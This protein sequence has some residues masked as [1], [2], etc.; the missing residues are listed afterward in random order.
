MKKTTLLLSLGAALMLA[1]CG[2]ANPNTK[3][4][5]SVTTPDVT[6]SSLTSVTTADPGTKTETEPV[7]SSEDTETDPVESS[8]LSPEESSELSPEE[9]SSEELPEELAGYEAIDAFY[10]NLLGNTYDLGVLTG[11]GENS[12]LRYG[13]SALGTNGYFTRALNNAGA[14]NVAGVIQ[15]KDLG[16]YFA[17][18]LNEVGEVVIGD[19]KG[20]AIDHK[21]PAYAFVYGAN[22]IAEAYAGK[23]VYEEFIYEQDEEDEYHF[24]LDLTDDAIKAYGVNIAGI[25]IG[26]GTGFNKTVFTA[27]YAALTKVSLDVDPYAKSGVFTFEVEWTNE[28]FIEYYKLTETTATW[29]VYVGNFEGDYEED[30]YAKAFL[31]YIEGDVRPAKPTKFADKG[32]AGAELDGVL[33]WYDGFDQGLVLDINNHA[34]YDYSL[35]SDAVH[36]YGVLLD[37]NINPEFNLVDVD[38]DKG[39]YTFELNLDPYGE[40][41]M[42]FTLQTVNSNKSMFPNGYFSLSWELDEGRPITDLDKINLRIADSSKAVNVPA[43]EVP[44]SDDVTGYALNDYTEMY[45]FYNNDAADLYLEVTVEIEEEKIN[46]YLEAFGAAIVAAYPDAEFL[47]GKWTVKLEDDRI[48]TFE[49]DY[50]AESE[51]EY[52]GEVTFSFLVEKPLVIDR[53]WVS[54]KIAEMNEDAFDQDAFQTVFDVNIVDISDDGYALI[55]EYVDGQFVR[56]TFVINANYPQYPV[57]AAVLSV[58]LGFETAEKRAAFVDEYTNTILAN[59]YIKHSTYPIYYEEASSSYSFGGMVEMDIP[60]T[61]VENE[62]FKLDFYVFANFYFSSKL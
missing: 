1:S 57:D 56:D 29:K 18:S 15:L 36:D 58:K 10:E 39:I 38:R 11:E 30:P 28:Q 34:I 44:A 31:N 62:S 5:S 59:G 26:S 24:E 14:F 54:G 8:E 13:I 52:A 12:V 3:T 7:P 33:P 6:D 21:N 27:N 23:S 60:E 4:D 42:V 55:D 61:D 20:N 37:T 50:D 16:G 22:D 53:A 17:A 35:G 49:C 32:E 51:D 46:G 40:N 19:M 47:E 43:I 45:N 41:V 2:G 25:T 48:V 9:S